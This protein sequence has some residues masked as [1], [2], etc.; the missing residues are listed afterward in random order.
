MIDNPTG[1]L[2]DTGRCIFPF[3]LIEQ[4]AKVQEQRSVTTRPF[5]SV[6]ASLRIR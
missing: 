3:E 5:G 2:Y 4:V 1:V 6:K